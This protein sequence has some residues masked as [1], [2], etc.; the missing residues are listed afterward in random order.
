MT[1]PPTVQFIPAAGGLTLVIHDDFSI[2]V[3]GPLSG[4]TPNIVDNGSNW[5]TYN[6]ETYEVNSVSSRVY[7]SNDGTDASKATTLDAGSSTYTVQ[8]ILSSPNWTGSARVGVVGFFTNGTDGSETF[9]KFDLFGGN[10]RCVE[11]SS[12]SASVSQT[13]ALSLTNN[14][15]YWFD[16]EVSGQSYTISV[17]NAARTVTIGTMSGSVS[18]SASNVCGLALVAQSSSNYCAE[19]KVYT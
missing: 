4:R 19:F 9:A 2:G 11:Y 15:E 5:T 6:S 18:L 1:P 3:T 14:T 10:L 16:L 13:S 7:A 12:G 17:L 8:A